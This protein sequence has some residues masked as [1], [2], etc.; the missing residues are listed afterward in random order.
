MDLG[1][2]SRVQTCG[3]KWAKGVMAGE[4]PRARVIA[5]SGTYRGSVGETGRLRTG[6]WLMERYGGMICVGW[7]PGAVLRFGQGGHYRWVEALWCA[8]DIAQIA[9]AFAGAFF[10]FNA[11]FLQGRMRREACCTKRN[12]GVRPQPTMWL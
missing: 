6:G 2:L 5:K 12:L 10:H 3:E 8:S 7:S 9:A 1:A 4:T 11:R